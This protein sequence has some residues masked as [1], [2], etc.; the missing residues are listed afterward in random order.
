MFSICE[1]ISLLYTIEPTLV[2]DGDDRTTF[3]ATV[4]KKYDI[5]V[6]F[7]PNEVIVGNLTDTIGGILARSNNGG[8]KIPRVTMPCFTYAISSDQSVRNVS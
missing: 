5:P 6:L 8:T 7:K 2:S 4:Y 1:Y 3:L